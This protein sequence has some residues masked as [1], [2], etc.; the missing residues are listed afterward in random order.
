[1]PCHVAHV[2][3]CAERKFLPKL[4]FFYRHTLHLFWRV[5]AERVGGGAFKHT[6]YRQKAYK[7]KRRNQ[8]D[9]N[10][11]AEPGHIEVPARHIEISTQRPVRVNQEI[12]NAEAERSAERRAYNSHRKRVRG[13]VAGNSA[14]FKAE[15]FKCSYLRFFFR[16]KA[17]HG[18]YHG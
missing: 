2:P 6:F 18:G 14:V 9:Y 10:G 5:G 7:R 4:A 13:I 8:C 11:E 3:F 1:M 15:R 12:S 17:V 16:G